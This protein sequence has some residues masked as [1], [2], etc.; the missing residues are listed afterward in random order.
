MLNWTTCYDYMPLDFQYLRQMAA[1]T[2][3]IDTI[4][5]LA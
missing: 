2:P 3:V 1:K 5:W 4:I